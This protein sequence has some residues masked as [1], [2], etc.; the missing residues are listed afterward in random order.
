MPPLL[1]LAAPYIA[2]VSP[3]LSEHDLREFLVC[4]SAA[5]GT[6]RYQG[7]A[8]PSGNDED[9]LVWTMPRQL[10]PLTPFRQSRD[11]EINLA[12]DV[13]DPTPKQIAGCIALGRRLETVDGVRTH[14]L[15]LRFNVTGQPPK[16]ESQGSREA[17]IGLRGFSRAREDTSAFEFGTG[18]NGTPFY[19]DKRRRAE[20]F[21][22][23]LK[24]ADL[25]D[26]VSVRFEDG[27]VFF[28]A[29][30]G[31]EIQLS[32]ADLIRRANSFL[33]RVKRPT[34]EDALERFELVLADPEIVRRPES[35]SVGLSISPEGYAALADE[36]N[37][38]ASGW[39]LDFLGGYR[40]DCDP[41]TADLAEAFD[42]RFPIFRWMLSADSSTFFEASIVPTP[43][44]RRI[45]IHSNCNDMK[46]LCKEAAAS[47]LSFDPY[48]FE[49]AAAR[50]PSQVTKEN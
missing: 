41:F 10:D 29:V 1:T 38:F 18:Y 33:C 22:A 35:L 5:K 4:I 42:G 40:P 20:L 43:E 27:M 25:I 24:R 26:R 11:C 34:Y 3:P 48:D 15:S 45:V 47:G 21:S 17:W 44:G 49:A 9:D 2:I 7:V 13:A 28:D 14:F 16:Q 6:R 31:Q 37:A 23:I 46:V 32:G 39:E 30:P 12:V 36:L 19:E 8:V 50:E